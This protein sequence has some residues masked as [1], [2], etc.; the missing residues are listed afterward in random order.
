VKMFNPM[1]GRIIM[2]AIEITLYSEGF[3]PDHYLHFGTLMLKI[4]SEAR[5]IA[6]DLLGRW[7]FFEK[8]FVRMDIILV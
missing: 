8:Y 3:F 5:F 7:L 4:I 1:I 6:S 2:N